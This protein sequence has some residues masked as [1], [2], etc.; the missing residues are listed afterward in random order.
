[1]LKADGGSGGRASSSPS[2][3]MHSDARG[4]GRRKGA[5]G[6]RVRC[7]ASVTH[8][9]LS[10][11]FSS[12]LSSTA[13]NPPHVSLR[14]REGTDTQAGRHRPTTDWWREGGDFS[15]VC[16]VAWRSLLAF[17]AAIFQRRFGAYRK[18]VR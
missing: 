12:P 11:L 2:A 3:A 18:V 8:M 9:H 15:G 4:A 1:V 6:Y 14:G 17:H 13:I 7:V 16:E 10:L 5:S